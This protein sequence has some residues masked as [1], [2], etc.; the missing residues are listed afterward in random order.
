RD[1]Q[2]R[3][4]RRDHARAK[5]GEHTRQRPLHR[6]HPPAARLAIDSAGQLAVS[7]APGA[8]GVASGRPGRDRR[9][10]A[11]RAKPVLPA[12][13]GT[14]PRPVA[15]HGAGVRR[16]RGLVVA[17]VGLMPLP[18]A[19]RK[20]VTITL[21]S[22]LL[23]TIVGSAAV[24]AWV[25]ATRGATRTPGLFVAD[26]VRRIRLAANFAGWFAGVPVRTNSLGLRDDR[27]YPA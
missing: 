12:P 20:I 10:V 1:R 7:H 27:E 2:R 4:G 23:V 25:R 16:D 14:E 18:G 21:P 13:T 8:A 15:R 17:R 22:L 24:E 9:A 3:A 6:R 5:G 26:P 19:V 11:G